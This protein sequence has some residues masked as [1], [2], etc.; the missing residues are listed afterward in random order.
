M[1][2]S[3]DRR[4][5]ASAICTTRNYRG[6]GAKVQH[7]DYCRGGSRSAAFVLGKELWSGVGLTDVLAA[8]DYVVPALEI[9]DA[10][11][12]GPRKISTVAR[13]RRSGGIVMGGR[14]VRPMDVDLRWVG[15]VMM[16]TPRSKRPRR[17]WC[18]RPSGDGR[19]VVA[20]SLARWARRWSPAI[21]CWRAGSTAWCSPRRATR[22]MAN[23]ASSAASPCSSCKDHLDGHA[24]ERFQARH[25]QTAIA[26]RAVVQPVQP[27]GDRGGV[28]FGL[29][30]APARHR[31]FAERRDRHLG[32]LQAAQKRH[33]VVHRAAGLERHGADQALSSISARRP[34][35]CRS[36]R[37]REE[38]KRA[39][40]STRYPPKGVRGIT[41]SGRAPAATA[42]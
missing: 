5:G 37:T 35:W 15:G 34:C 10:A 9:V 36:C 13:Q 19:G 38:A 6:I 41:G 26:D 33:R 22:C 3:E 8:T 32:H 18:A 7:S 16:S 27:G 28:A 12:A 17:R 39:V 25:R 21:S 4:A 11:R 2:C 42:A 40:E 23:S 30:L 1:Q 14:P 31:A 29:R 20:N 24:A